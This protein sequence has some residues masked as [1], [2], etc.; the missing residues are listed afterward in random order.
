MR[1]HIGICYILTLFGVTYGDLHGPN[2]LPKSLL[3]ED[4]VLVSITNGT[5]KGYTKLNRYGNKVD[6]F[7]GVPYAQPPV[8]NLRFKRPK[9]LGVNDVWPEDTYLDA[10]PLDGVHQFLRSKHCFSTIAGPNDLKSG[11]LSNILPPISIGQEDCLYLDIT[12]PHIESNEIQ[13]SDSCPSGLKP[14]MIWLPGGAYVVGTGSGIF[15]SINED[16]PR[17]YEASNLAGRGDVVI[18]S[19]TYR[20]G[21]LG[22]LSLG[23]NSDIQGNQGLYDQEL[24]IKWVYENIENFCGNPD[25]IT[26]FGQSAGGLSTGIQVANPRLFDGSKG[27][28]IIKKAILMSGSPYTNWGITSNHDMQHK[29]DIVA[30]NLKNCQARRRDQANNSTESDTLNLENCLM[31]TEVEELGAA[32]PILPW[33]DMI[34][35]ENPEMYYAF[36][37]I[38]D[39]ELVFDPRNLPSHVEEIKNQKKVMVGNLNDDGY[40]LDILLFP[41][42]FINRTKIERPSLRDYE[43]S[44]GLDLNDQIRGQH[45]MIQQASSNFYT[46][47]G[48]S[49]SLLVQEI[50][51]QTYDKFDQPNLDSLVRDSYAR[52][53]ATNL[54]TDLMFRGPALEYAVNHDNQVFVYEFREP[55]V[56]DDVLLG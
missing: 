2:I 22:F 37:P 3:T 36:N 26:V 38:V 4:N 41:R 50:L 21:L 27:T 39:N 35:N 45:H 15:L 5:I 42:L 9:P 24:A 54:A 16:Q 29:V 49:Q 34:F 25:D 47:D 19:V 23:P 48:F 20:V 14:V 8:R 31:Y 56:F 17:L 40:I 51:Q 13:D 44:L 43:Y 6:T 33:V 32:Y 18:V 28:S 1:I 52:Q 46:N 55:S 11:L 12:R 53:Q 7:T 30:G 10:K